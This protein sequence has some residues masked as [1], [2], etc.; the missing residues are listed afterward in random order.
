MLSPPPPPL[1][2]TGAPAAVA[3]PTVQPDLTALAGSILIKFSREV[4][5]TGNA[6]TLGSLDD[7]FRNVRAV[8]QLGPRVSVHKHAAHSPHLAG[9][10]VVGLADRLEAKASQQL[11]NGA[12][13]LR[14]AA[15]RL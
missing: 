15:V 7:N 11:C 8:R 12:V 9:W 1:T 10:R 13:L 14:A 5:T 6:V 4:H 2:T 3:A